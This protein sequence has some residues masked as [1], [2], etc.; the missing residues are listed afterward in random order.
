[1]DGLLALFIG[2]IELGISLVWLALL[3]ALYWRLHRIGKPGLAEIAWWM[4]LVPTA[5]IACILAIEELSGAGG[6]MPELLASCV[7][8]TGLMVIR[9]KRPVSSYDRAKNSS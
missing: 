3:I 9:A 1:M 6:R 4:V 8:L 7:W 2:L 5:L